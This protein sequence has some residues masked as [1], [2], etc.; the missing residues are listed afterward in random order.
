MNGNISNKFVNKN[1]NFKKLD[2][3]LFT[4]FIGVSV[5]IQ[6]IQLHVFTKC[7]NSWKGVV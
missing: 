2:I 3:S 1:E 7:R 6:E 5:T 4:F